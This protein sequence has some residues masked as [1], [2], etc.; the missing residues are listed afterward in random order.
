MIFKD[1]LTPLKKNGHYFEGELIIPEGE[2]YL[3]AKLPDSNYYHYLLKYDG[4]KQG[5]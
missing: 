1:A 3:G 5:Q 2:F 4:W